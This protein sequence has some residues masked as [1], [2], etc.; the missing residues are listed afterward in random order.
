MSLH[1]FLSLQKIQDQVPP[2]VTMA[3]IPPDVYIGLEHI[4]VSNEWQQDIISS[5]VV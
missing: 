3:T 2:G 1:I 4:R 5:Y